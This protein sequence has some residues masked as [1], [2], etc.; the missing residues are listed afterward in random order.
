[1]EQD[2]VIL[3]HQLIALG[4]NYARTSTH[5]ILVLNQ[6]RVYFQAIHDGNY[7]TMDFYIDDVARTLTTH[8]IKQRDVF[9]HTYYRVCPAPLIM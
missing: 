5:E 3:A 2:A 7:H 1:M 9:E 6:S 8:K 4:K